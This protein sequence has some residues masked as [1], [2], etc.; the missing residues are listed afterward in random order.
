MNK[1]LN[2][3]TSISIVISIFLIVLGILLMTF[4]DTSITVFGYSLAM[5]LTC[6]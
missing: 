6:L 3:Y 4:T 2:K 5:F 1:I